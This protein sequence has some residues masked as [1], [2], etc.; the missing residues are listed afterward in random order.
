MMTWQFMTWYFYIGRFGRMIFWHVAL[1]YWLMVYWFKIME[2][3]GFE[4]RT[5][6]TSQIF[7]KVHRANG[8]HVDP[9]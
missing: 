8:S 9:C 2:S 6:H 1:L 5:S 4:P 7:G 3:V